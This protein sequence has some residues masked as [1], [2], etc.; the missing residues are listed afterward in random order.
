MPPARRSYW[1]ATRIGSARSRISAASRSSCSATPPPPNSALL[2]GGIDYL[3]GEVGLSLEQ[4]IEIE[5]RHRDRFRFVYKPS[6]VYEHI[7]ANL[8]HPILKD[9]RVRQALLLAID[10]ETI[11]SEV[12]GGKNPVAHS[13]SLPEEALGEAGVLRYPH[14]PARAKALLDAAG[15]DTIR[16]GVRH[17]AAG[18]RLAFAFMTT[19]GNR[20]RE[21]VQQSVQRQWREIGV[22]AR[23]VNQPTAVL[24]D[25]TLKQRTF[26]GVVLKAWFRSPLSTGS[27]FLHS[28]QIPTAANNYAGQNYTGFRAADRVFDALARA[29]GPE[30]AAL[31]AEMQKIYTEELPELP[32]HFRAEAYVMPHWLDGVEPTGHLDH[33]TNRVEFWRVK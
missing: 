4:A 2:S 3:A 33:S 23:I 5:A 12:Y 14:D 15:W 32:L 17:D 21:H 27:F 18:Q 28:A 7:A 16:D 30:R 1:S 24:F 29:G 8:D 19:A 20:G 9:K 11:L 10:R 31:L 26:D 6:L 22:E 13:F 25:V